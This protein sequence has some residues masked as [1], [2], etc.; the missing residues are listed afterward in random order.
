[1]SNWSSF[2]NDQLVM[3]SWR[4]FSSEQ[5]EVLNEATV[6]DSLKRLGTAAKNILADLERKGEVER[7]AEEALK[8]LQ[9]DPAFKIDQAGTEAEKAAIIMD[10]QIKLLQELIARKR[11]ELELGTTGEMEKK[12][13]EDTIAKATAKIEQIRTGGDKPAAAP[14]EQP[15]QKNIGVF[16]YMGPV[17]GRASTGAPQTAD[18]ARLSRFGGPPAAAGGDGAEGDAGDGD[19]SELPK[20]APL[21]ITKR[22]QDLRVGDEQRKEQ[23]L[24]MQLQKIGM[25]QQSAQ[26]I[27]KRIGKYLKQRNIPV[28]EG[29]S[30]I[31]EALLNEARWTPEA[32]TVLRYI[33]GHASKLRSTDKEFREFANSFI[34]GIHNIAKEQNPDKFRAF[35]KKR[36][37]PRSSMPAGT[38]D[39]ISDD[40]IK[41]LMKYTRNDPP[42]RRR[43]RDA[44]DYR[45]AK[46][47]AKS[48]RRSD[49]RSGKEQNVMAKIMAR[50][51]SDN[52]KLLD[53]DPALKAIFDDPQKFNKL[54]KSVTSFIRR[55]FKRRGYSEDEYVKLLQEAFRCELNKMLLEE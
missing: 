5:I 34:L 22:Q 27:A 21:S 38:I 42:F 37:S 12:A 52:Q 2:K 24:V 55:Q 11:A 48:A 17:T 43:A 32:R 9:D 44:F 30:I 3:E 8:A 45:Q 31:K 25:S 46:K 28:A 16:N 40:E 10:R 7:Y 53:K 39:A 54:R 18:L 26:Q 47:A 35:L 4:S 29:M 13:I 50:F 23:P 15:K 20:D 19:E 36:K 33:Y 51:V 1:M 14:A 6:A 49:I 41:E